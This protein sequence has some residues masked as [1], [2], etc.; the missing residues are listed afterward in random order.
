VYSFVTAPAVGDRT[1]FS[2]AVFGDMG[3]TSSNGI[4]QSL[5][6]SQNTFN[7]IYHIG[8][9]S[10]ADD[11]WQYLSSYEQV[12]AQWM[13][14]IEPLSNNRP[15]MV[16]PGN[17]ETTCQEV[18]PGLCDSKVG[19]FSTYRTRWRMPSAESGG[20]DSMWHSFDFG[21]IHFIQIDTETDF[22]NAPEGVGTSFNAGPFGDQLTWLQND[23]AKA[24]N[25]RAN[26]PW[27]IVSGHRP[28][29]YTMEKG[30]FGLVV[31]DSNIANVRNAFLPILLQ[32]NVDIY[33]TGHKHDYERYYPIN[34]NGTVCQTNYNNPP[35]N[36]PIFIVHGAAGN[37][38]G[39]ESPVGGP[40]GSPPY[41]AYRDNSNYGWGRLTL[42]NISTLKWEFI[43]NASVVKDTAFITKNYT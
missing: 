10:Y 25:N 9:I 38:E 19:N 22:P 43:T 13:D 42:V 15:W 33:F 16:L 8:D 41:L 32:H 23:L 17:H 20:V 7:W 28:I 14:E 34:P 2:I 30:P 36:C 31:I 26:V 6:A 27:I 1:P 39:H 37:I 40:N 5:I 35:S 12:Y 24:N 11:W 29:W 3:V 4:S 21:P 18:A